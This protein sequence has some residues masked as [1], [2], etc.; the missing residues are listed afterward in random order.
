[1]RVFEPASIGTVELPNRIL[2]S[3]TFEGLCDQ[4]G[5]PGPAYTGLYA[6]L[7][8]QGLGG[9][10]TGFAYVSAEGKAMQPGQAG[11]ESDAKV[12][13]FR[14]VTEA[15][16]R[17]GGR[18]FLQLAHA[19]RQTTPAAAGGRVY[20]PSARKSR[21]FNHRP[22]RLTVPQIE[23]LATR[24]GAAARRAREAGFDGVQLHAAHGYLLH[25]FIHPAINDRGDAYGIDPRRGIGTAFVDR[26][27]G[28]VRSAC[29]ADYPLLI[30]I[31]AGDNYRRPLREKEFIELVRFLEGRALAAVEISFGTMDHALNIFRGQ[32]IPRQTILDFNPR[33]GSRQALRRWVCRVLLLPWLKRQCAPFAP[34]Y[35]LAYARLAKQHTKIPVISVGGFRSAR[36]IRHAIEEQGIDFVSLCR[37]I[38][39]E[40]GFVLKMR[41]DDRYESRCRNCN[42]CAVMCDS[43]QPTRCYG[44]GGGER[45]LASSESKSPSRNNLVEV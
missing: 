24:F 27:I 3:A 20:A 6:R 18:I 43:G 34:M 35:N 10:I 45:A 15:V 25:Q 1:M 22:C 36:H 44:P 30:K 5:N 32:S 21:Y 31:S 9:L 11:L 28:E 2:R 42:R 41:Q 33:Y 12:G 39:C 16:R 4:E 29:G 38:L 19:G 37:P 17:N 7:S 40:P 23:E 13:A 26:V 14:G 8:C